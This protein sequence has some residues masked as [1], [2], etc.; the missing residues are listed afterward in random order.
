MLLLRANVPFWKK[1]KKKGRRWVH[2][3]FVLNGAK[4][5]LATFNHIRVNTSYMKNRLKIIPICIWS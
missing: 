3:V 2:N 5:C 4:T 1:K